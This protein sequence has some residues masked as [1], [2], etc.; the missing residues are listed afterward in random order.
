MSDSETEKHM[1][2]V[3]LTNSNYNVWAVAMQGKLM[4]V[5]A[6]WI[7]TEDL[8]RPV[9]TGEAEKWLLKQEEAAGI[10]LKSLT[11]TQ[12]VH[13]EGIMDN[14]IEMWNRLR[15][16]HRSQVANSHFHAMQKLLSIWKEDGELLTDYIT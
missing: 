15:A 11:P 5:N 2:S 9:N 4:T 12:Y 1:K 6:W 3:K 10:I 8:K 7:I 13:I 16:V 14:P